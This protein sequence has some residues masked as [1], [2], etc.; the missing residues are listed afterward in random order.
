MPTVFHE[1]GF[2]FYFYS[3]DCQEKPHVHVDGPSGTAKI[4]LSTLDFFNSSMSARDEK[5]ALEIVTK[6]IAEI[7]AAWRKH[8]G[9]SNNQG[10]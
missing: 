10:D 4:W 9:S 2:K 8:C 7:W 1:K 5:R 3:S 6:R